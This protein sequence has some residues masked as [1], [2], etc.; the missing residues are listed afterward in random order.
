MDDALN[1][2]PVLAAEDKINSGES[3]G[4]FNEFID[5]NLR[6]MVDEIINEGDL[7]SFGD[8]QSDIII[9]MDDISPPRFTYGSPQ[10]GAGG[11][12]NQGPGEGAERIRFALPF[13]RLMELIADK[14]RLPSLI[15]EGQGK[16]KEVSYE[17][18]TFG[19]AGVILDKKRTFRRALR[20][21]IGTGSF[22][23][24]EGRYDILIRR[25]DR[26]FKLPE[27]VEKPKFKAVV[28]YMGDI[29]YSTYGE[30]LELE[31]R[32]VGFIHNWLNLGHIST[33]TKSEESFPEY[34]AD[35]VSDLRSSL[36]HFV[37]QVIWSEESDY[38]ELF[39]AK[40]GYTNSRIADFYGENW[41]PKTEPGF[42]L[43]QTEDS[44]L[45]SGL[46]THPLLLSGLAYR[47]ST[48]PIHRGVF[49]IRYM[50][51]RTLRPPSEAFTPLS[52]DLHPDLTTRERVELQTS[53]DG[54][55]TCHS[56]I[57]GLGFV[58][59]NFDAVGF[60]R[61]TEKSKPIDALGQYTDRKDNSVK[62]N[63]VPD[64]ASYLADSDDAHR[65]FVSRA[66][67]HFVKQPPA[68]FGSE[69]LDRLV[70]LFRENDYNVRELLT[71]IIVLAS[72]SNSSSSVQIDAS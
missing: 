36:D 31:K 9:E 28:F 33:I 49:L 20:S 43:A 16:I 10:G 25:R 8:R 35:L 62:F 67:Q 41:K 45:H 7:E 13:D 14:L 1:I 23:P 15:K 46:L 58:L 22:C 38:R 29:S 21:S 37:E 18:K 71:E 66:F 54:C 50:L 68:A 61:E 19:T 5:E 40:Y 57:N 24:Q 55:Q 70:R 6:D 51:G 53:P 44:E 39:L 59:E 17:F 56:K 72:V 30:R 4:A 2:K 12:G 3:E 64:L 26:R 34:D 47:D 52:P 63:G 60:Y 42:D 65:A 69:T 32:V 27:R 11:K 48:S